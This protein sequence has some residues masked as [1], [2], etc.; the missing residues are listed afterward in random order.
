MKFRKIV[1]T[2]VLVS[3][4]LG[5]CTGL[6]STNDRMTEQSVGA[7]EGQTAEAG[8]TEAT[9]HAAGQDGNA[10]EP[11]V[12]YSVEEM[13][14]PDPISRI[15]LR[16]G[17]KCWYYDV[18]QAGD[19]VACSDRGYSGNYENWYF[20]T[21]IYDSTAGEWVTFDA[22]NNNY[23][24]EVDGVTYYGM[25]NVYRSLDD[26]LYTNAYIPDM[27]GYLCE[28]DQN[29]FR[30]ILYAIPEI[31]QEIDGDYEWFLDKEKRLYLYS[32]EEKTVRCYDAE[33]TLPG[34]W[35]CPEQFMALC[36]ETPEKMFTGMVPI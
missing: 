30:H 4:L 1:T 17:E 27:E 14:F 8:S 7:T 35:R 9:G 3:L 24:A 11:E 28:T 22:T 29:G 32:A 25:Q 18:F 33:G 31:E 19:M 12:L 20:Y 36:R 5:G 13:A 23:K 10:D 34:Q 21:Q 15:D 16:E 2:L 6:K 26:K